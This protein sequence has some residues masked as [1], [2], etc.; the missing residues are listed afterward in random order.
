MRTCVGGKSARPNGFI[1][2]S[3][4]QDS[5]VTERG[6]IT[7]RL[8]WNTNKESSKM[9]IVLIQGVSRAGAF[10]VAAGICR[11]LHDKTANFKIIWCSQ[12]THYP[13]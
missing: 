12:S 10:T 1:E 4:R 8:L 11:L 2:V 6:E 5:L 7:A 9:P 13:S 3:K